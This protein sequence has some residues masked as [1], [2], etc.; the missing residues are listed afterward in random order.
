MSPLFLKGLPLAHCTSFQHYS[1][2]NWRA[3]ISVLNCLL[4]I[5]IAPSLL[6]LQRLKSLVT[7]Y[8]PIK[9]KVG[10]E[11]KQEP[12]LLHWQQ[13][14]DARLLENGRHKIL[15]LGVTHLLQSGN[16]WGFWWKF[17]VI[18]AL[19]GFWNAVALPVVLYV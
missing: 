6:L 11:K 19:L 12:L 5:K 18:L 16:H 13:W 9:C 8:L 7:T 14:W 15:F 2:H 3:S 10:G 17:P 4:G 1:S